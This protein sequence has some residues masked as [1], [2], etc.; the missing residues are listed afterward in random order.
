MKTM[1]SMLIMGLLLFNLNIGLMAQE[2]KVAAYSIETQPKYVAV[3]ENM[4]VNLIFPYAVKKVQ[5]V[6]TAIAVQEF[7]GVENILLVKANKKGFPLTNVSV[8]TGD[9]RFYSFVIGYASGITALNLEFNVTDAKGIVKLASE[10]ETNEVS[11]KKYAEQIMQKR[12]GKRNKANKNQISLALS[13]IYIQGNHL[14]FRLDIENDSNIPYDIDQLKFY[15]QDKKRA[16]RTASQE[17]EQKPDYIYREVAKL[18][19]KSSASMVFV[20]P[21]FTIPDQKILRIHMIEKNGGRHLEIKV[22]NGSLVKAKI[23]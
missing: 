3:N 16:K 11:F 6:S 15:I 14:Y 9:G 4:A 5:W 20:L 21:K 22:K 12:A 2:K 23:L 1:K 19:G 7:K 17:L 18:N 10:N 8:V 13:D